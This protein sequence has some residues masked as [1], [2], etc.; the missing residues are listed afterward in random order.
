MNPLRISG[1]LEKPNEVE[2]SVR[3]LGDPRLSDPS[4]CENIPEL[5]RLAAVSPNGQW[6]AL[7]RKGRGLRDEFYTIS[8]TGEGAKETVIPLKNEWGCTR[9]RDIADD[10][11][12]LFGAELERSFSDYGF[13]RRLWSLCPA[14]TSLSCCRRS[15]R[16]VS[17]LLILSRTIALA[18]T[19]RTATHLMAPSL[20][21]RIPTMTDGGVWKVARYPTASGSANHLANGQ[22]STRQTS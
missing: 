9:A 17:G 6:M 2:C 22:S 3:V 16:T 11:A 8:Q 19:H 15:T 21:G 20:A 13:S 4:V 7:V 5:E 1:L 10:G 18:R 12:F 14:T